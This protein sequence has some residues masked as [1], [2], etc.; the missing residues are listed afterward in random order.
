MNPELEQKLE[1]DVDCALRGLPDLVAPPGFLART[2]AA[3]QRPAAW[4]PVGL[5]NKWPLPVRV[6]FLSVALSLLAASIFGWRAIEPGVFAAVYRSA[7]PAIAGAKCFWSVLL[8]LT[9]AGALAVEHLGK[10]VMLIC[11]LAAL[12]ASAICGG[13]GSVLIRFALGRPR[14]SKL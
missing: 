4:L 3:L 12:T 8:A 7:A 1:A 11:A 14:N 9:G 2:M 5:W 6:A 13:F 10:G